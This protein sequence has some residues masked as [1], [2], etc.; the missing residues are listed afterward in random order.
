[1]RGKVPE[2]MSDK[3]FM[4]YVESKSVKADEKAVKKV[5]LGAT[6]LLKHAL[7]I[8]RLNNDELKEAEELFNEAAEE[9][10][11]IGDYENDLVARSWVLRVEAIKG[12][13][14]V[15]EFR[16][17]Y[18]EAF[19]KER[20][21]L[22]AR[23]LSVASTRLGNYLVSLALTGGDEEVKKIKELL[24]EH[25]LVLNAD[26]RV[27]ILTRL[28]LNA[29]L[30]SKDRKDQLG[31]E[32]KD[33]LSV[34]PKELIDILKPHMHSELLPALMVAFGVKTPEDGIKSCEEFNNEVCIDFVLV[35]KGNSAA[36]EQLRERVINVF[37]NSL[38]GLSF[39]VES[40]INEF[41][42]LVNGFDGKS[43]VQLIAPTTSMAWLA[44]MLHALINGDEKLAKALALMGAVYTTVKLS[45]R[46]F[47]EAY[48]A[49]CDLKSESFR[50]AIARLF[51]LH[52]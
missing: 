4:D 39:D 6:S 25:L 28:T 42:G 20:F 18:E 52:V 49:C 9:S 24:E 50:R 13:L 8:Y 19:N 2:L 26:R 51:F 46:L 38:K 41:R 47:L 5:I 30:G 48:K 1:L 29:L 3:E 43:L 37:H 11:E 34:E 40:L 12:S 33:K 27:S 14:L 15:D 35:A 22:T 7:A 23:Y 32:L 44:L 10:R 45:T 21:R 16:R 17:L 36:V 31:S